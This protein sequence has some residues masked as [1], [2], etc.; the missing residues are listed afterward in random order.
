VPE[1][2]PVFQKSSIGINLFKI[3]IRSKASQ[4]VIIDKIDFVGKCG[5]K[6]FTLLAVEGFGVQKVKK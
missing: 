6:V 3:K 4:M 1:I 2:K 5:A